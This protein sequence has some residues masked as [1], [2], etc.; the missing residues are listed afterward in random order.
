MLV[1]LAPAAVLAGA[2]GVVAGGWRC[3]VGTAARVPVVVDVVAVR[4]YG[5]G[6]LVFVDRR[7]CACRRP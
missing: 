4:P 5:I 3:V 2:L 6:R 1:E 7:C